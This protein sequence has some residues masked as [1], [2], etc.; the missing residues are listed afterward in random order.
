MISRFNKLQ[1]ESYVRRGYALHGADENEANLEMQIAH[2]AQ[3][4]KQPWPAVNGRALLV[5]ARCFNDSQH[6]YNLICDSRTDYARF[7]TLAC[8]T[9]W[10]RKHG[11]N[12]LILVAC[13]ADPYIPEQIQR[14]VVFK[15]Q[16]K[17][18]CMHN[19][20]IDFLLALPIFL[21]VL[22]Q[23]ELLLLVGQPFINLFQFGFL[24]KIVARLH[25]EKRIYLLH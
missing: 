7:Y 20:L 12:V 11:C 1:I 13:G 4:A 16:V 5:A 9:A 3:I 10:D 8:S 6:L 23:V 15:T 17:L 18:A 14:S 21:P 24:W 22:L 25:N 2:D 19:Y